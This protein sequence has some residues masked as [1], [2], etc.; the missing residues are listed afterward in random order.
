MLAGREM[1]A[2]C[3]RNDLPD[4][5][6]YMFTRWYSD[7]WWSRWARSSRP[8]N[9]P[10]AKTTMMIEAHWRVLKREFLLPFPRPRL[11]L[12]VWVI[13]HQLLLMSRAKF[14]LKIINRRVP[15]EWEMEFCRAWKSLTRKIAASSE[16]ADADQRYLPSL[17]KWTCGCPSFGKSRFMLCRHL[18]QRCND[19]VRRRSSLFHAFQ[20][21]INRKDTRPYVAIDPVCQTPRYSI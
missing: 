3:V 15:L 8:D 12:L 4:V 19:N 1:Y 11:D 7:E 21:Y 20:V 16:S 2:F 9:I 14:D 5:W 17:E 10:M 6:A 18:V 13:T